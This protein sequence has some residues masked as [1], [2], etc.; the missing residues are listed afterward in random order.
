MLTP[1]NRDF[2]FEMVTS[3]SLER[4]EEAHITYITQKFQN[5]N[6]LPTLVWY[7]VQRLNKSLEE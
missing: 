6:D 5:F 4:T 7:K 3:E 1:E 2:L